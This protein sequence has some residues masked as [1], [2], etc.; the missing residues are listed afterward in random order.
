MV[1]GEDPTIL[2]VDEVALLTRGTKFT[3]RRVLDKERFLRKQRRHM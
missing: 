2:T 1:V 3:I